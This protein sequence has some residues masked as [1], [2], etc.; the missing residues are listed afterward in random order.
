[1]GDAFAALTNFTKGLEEMMYFR[2]RNR[3]KTKNKKKNFAGNCVIFPRNQVKTKKRKG[4]RRNLR[5][6]LAGNLK[7]LTVFFLWTSSAQL[8]MRGRINLDGGTLNIDG[9]LLSMGDASP[10]VPPTI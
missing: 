5:P 9:T 1:M 2:R 4:L 8:W 7:D 10:R 3:M 6:F